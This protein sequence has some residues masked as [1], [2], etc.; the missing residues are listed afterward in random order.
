VAEV[1][2][3]TVSTIKMTAEQFLQLGED[4]PGVRLELV[5]GEI[6]VSPSPIPKHS[7]TDKR[8]SHILMSHILENELGE[9]LGDVDTIFGPYDVRRPDIIY[10]SKSSLKRIG[11]K[12]LEAPPDLCVEIL[13]PSSVKIDRKDKFAQYEAAKVPNYWIVDPEECTAEAFVLKKGKYL[14]A[15]EGKGKDVVSFPPFL[16]LKIPLEQIWFRPP[17]K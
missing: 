4:P 9:L 17:T 3:M 7:I 14:A 10:F 16:D 2:F 12:S 5:D 15:G 6:A 11:E 13:S 8:L 1:S